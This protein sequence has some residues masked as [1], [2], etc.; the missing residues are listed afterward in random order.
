MSDNFEAYFNVADEIE[1]TLLR[2]LPQDQ[3]T[4]EPG[5]GLTLADLDPEWVAQAK[6]FADERNFPWP[7]VLWVAEEESN[8]R[9]MKAWR[10][11]SR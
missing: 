8:D 1:Q 6:Q 9:A 7:P 3:E 5:G 10:E 4:T 11:R 2:G